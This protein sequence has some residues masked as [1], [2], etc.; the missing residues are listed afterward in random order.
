MT[1]TDT[2][3]EPFE[4]L[5]MDIVGPINPPS[6][7]GNGYIFT[8]NC[9]LTK[10]AI[11]VPIPDTTALTT[12]K[13]FV[14]NV[15]LKYGLAET[16]VSD[17]GTNFT[18][19][20]LKE[21]NKLLKIKRI[22]TSPYHPQSNQVERFHKSLNNY[23]KAFVQSEP[24]RWCEYVDFAM[25][26]YNNTH[27]TATGFSPFELVYGRVAKLPSEITNKRVPVYNYDNYA[28]ELRLKLK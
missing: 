4:K 22:F 11:A 2:A 1:I 15:V 6:D 16:I 9:S 17:N 23:L 25:F 8:F 3:S 5:Y 18:S 28:E 14:H 19:E 10:F 27:N 26:A 24:N 12:A 7:N 20:L 21:V 13:A